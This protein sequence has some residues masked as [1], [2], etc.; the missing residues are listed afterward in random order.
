MKV[1]LNYDVDTVSAFFAGITC[2]ALFNPF[3]RAMFLASNNKSPVFI[4]ANFTK[5]F[6]GYVQAVFQRAFVY[7]FLQ[8]KLEHAM[9]PYFRDQLNL[10][11]NI[12][13]LCLGMS[14]GFINGIV[15]NPVIATKHQMW[16]KDSNT[17]FAISK[18]MW[19]EG[20]CKSFSNGMVSS[21]VRNMAF[22]SVYEISRGLIGKTL[23]YY[24]GNDQ[25]K[26]R[27]SFFSNLIAAGFGT[28]IVS[29]FI[30]MRSVQHA[31]PPGQ[32][33]L[34]LRAMWR[35]V[36]VKSKSQP[37]MMKR[38]LF[39]PK[40]FKTCQGALGAALRWATAQQ[41]CDA[42]RDFL[43]DKEKVTPRC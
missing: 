36:F 42:T 8:A 43:K 34:T 29:P 40:E 25:N 39:F 35:D 18:K 12:E 16:T 4:W 21:I 41:I 27:L 7:L 22:G 38:M 32:T 31:T 24:A 11:E 3:D 23:V 37:T 10:N 9:K 15:M 5:P 19:M 1:I 6:H 26:M 33:P 17:F 28:M 30:Y 2:A 14:A 13:K 20:G